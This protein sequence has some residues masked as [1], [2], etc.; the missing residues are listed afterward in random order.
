MVSSLSRVLVVLH[1]L[2]HRRSA[3]EVTWLIRYMPVFAMGVLNTMDEKPSRKSFSLYL[4]AMNSATHAAQNVE[5][6]MDALA[7]WPRAR[8]FTALT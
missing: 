7:G 3:S 5:G 4:A 2:G 1:T 6:E 8:G